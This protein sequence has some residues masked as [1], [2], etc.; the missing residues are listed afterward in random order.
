M[1]TM[2]I[3]GTF[4]FS[5]TFAVQSVHALSAY[6]TYEGASCSSN[7]TIEGD[8]FMEWDDSQYSDFGLSEYNYSGDC[9][10]F[11]GGSMDIEDYDYTSFASFVGAGYCVSCDNMVGCSSTGSC[12]DFMTYDAPEEN[13][14]VENAPEANAPEENAPEENDPVT[15]ETSTGYQLTQGSKQIVSNPSFGLAKSLQASMAMTV[16][17]PPSTGSGPGSL[18]V[19]LLAVVAA[20]AAVVGTV[21]AI[22][23]SRWILAVDTSGLLE[24]TKSAFSSQQQQVLV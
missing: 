13:A 8:A 18:V 19:S 3:L 14:P 10:Y 7:T 12:H 9:L 6:W 24:M 20:V 2:T 21:A 11:L 17:Q 4:G 22:R 15:E 1:N 16:S 5:L 23:R